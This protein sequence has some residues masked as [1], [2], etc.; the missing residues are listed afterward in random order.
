MDK[1]II[2]RESAEEAKESI[3]S[4][5]LALKRWNSFEE[6]VI[7]NPFYHPKSKR[8]KKLKTTSYP[9]GTYRYKKEPLR[10]VYYL[11]REKRTIYP[12]DA[13][14][15]TNIAYKRRSHR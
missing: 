15:S 4:N 1:W 6:D 11:N 9:E 13:G 10:V 3:A 5:T 8:I 7:D 2:D 14:T 12:L